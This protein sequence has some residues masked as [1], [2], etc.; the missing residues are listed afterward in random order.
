MDWLKIIQLVI[1]LA[2]ATVILLQNKGAG[3]SGLFGGSGGNV[4]S[5]KRGLEKTLHRATIILSVLFFIISLV[6]VI[7]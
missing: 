1:A 5:S 6:I 7:L 2:L 3:V 4:Y